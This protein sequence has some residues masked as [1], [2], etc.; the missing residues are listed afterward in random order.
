MRYEL[1][2]WTDALGWHQLDDGSL[3]GTS[4]THRALTAGTTY[5]YAV[6]ALAADGTASDW[7]EHA[8]AIASA[9]QNATA[10]NTPTNTPTS[11]PDAS[12]STPT[13]TSAST[14]TP[15]ATASASA[16]ALSAPTLTAQ[17]GAGQITL[18]WNAISGAVRYE[19]WA[20][21]DA[22]GWHQLDDGGL[23]GTSYTHDD[24][25]P[26][27]TYWYAVRAVAANGAAS[28]WS[29]HAT[30]TATPTAGPTQT[31]TAT[32]QPIPGSGGDPGGPAAP[33]LTTT[34]GTNWIIVDW[35]AVAGAE[36]YDILRRKGENGT[37]ERPSGLPQTTA[38]HGFLGLDF[39]TTYYYIARAITADGKV[40]PWSNLVQDSPTGS[41]NSTPTP[42]S[43]PTATITPTPDGSAA[44]APALRAEAT[45]TNAIELSWPPV[46][47][48]VRYLLWT[49]W[50]AAVG[51]QQ[52]DDGNLTGASYTH[53][54][55]APGT[56]YHYAIR[57]VDANGTSSPW[58]DYPFAT[59]PTAIAVTATATTSTPATATPTATATATTSTLATATPTATTPPPAP[60]AERAALVA[61]YNATGGA[62]W[63]RSANWLSDEPIATWYGVLTDDSGNV[64]GL[65][66]EHNGLSGPL[67]DLSALT[68]LK[69]L[70][71]GYNDLTGPLPD[72]SALA[73]LARL[74]LYINDLSGPLPDLGALTNL[75][76]LYLDGN[77]LTGQIPDLSNL[78][79]LEYLGLSG[80]RLTGQIPDLSNHAS[81][82]SLELNDN[83]LAGQIPD[84]SNLAR[85]EYLGLSGNELTGQIPDLSNLANLTS[86]WL[87][88]NQ[89][90]GQIPDLSN[91]ASLEYLGL[92]GNQLSG[93]IP[94]LSNLVRL[95]NLSLSHNQLTG[96][97]PDLNALANLESVSLNHNRLAGQI[98]ELGA[99]TRLTTLSLNHNLLTG[100]IPDLSTLT[101]LTSLDLSHNQL[102]GSILDLNSL[103][104][105]QTLSL[106]NNQLT[107]PFPDLSALA[108]L[109]FLNLTGNRLC[110]PA[111]SDLSGSN[112]A[113]ANHLNSLNLATCTAA[114]LAAALAAPQ[115]LTATV[116]SG[117]VTLTWDAATRAASYDLRVWDSFDRTWAP[118]GGALRN[119]TYTHT[120]LT[121]GRN[122]YYQVRARD[123]NGVRGA[124]SEQLY[125]AV[126][127]T[128]FPPPPQSFGLDMYYQKYM[129][130][131]GID[132]FA[133]S[134]YTDE[135]MV[136]ARQIITGMLANRSD[137]LATMAANN[138][139]IYVRDDFVGI[140]E[141][142]LAYMP[143]ADPHCAT[144]IHEYAHVIH[145]ALEA[146]A[147]GRAFN[148]RL[149]AAYQAA[150][151][152]GLWRGMYASTNFREYWAEAVKYWLWESLPP[153]LAANYPKPADYDP[154]VVKLIEEE[155]GAAAVP[156][157]CKP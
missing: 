115:N 28:D 86:L 112:T 23:T 90:N 81:L 33:V 22:L 6:R 68:S 2:A 30:A 150:V 66:L 87:N 149:H 105:L 42:T 63:T 72:L 91:L 75:T 143:T 32:G 82:T 3:T 31:P 154:G 78:A 73:N 56:T 21:T 46:P 147:G 55:L 61:L 69:T 109:A 127:P 5:W 79:R 114:E 19:L 136:R 49:W 146:Q 98:P 148:A 67:P 103:T 83:R 14:S 52:L 51:W 122:Y 110:L 4:Y 62:N 120:V 95:T 137:L 44:R 152:G 132:V 41:L 157:S 133:P 65:D 88:D 104:K 48:A 106:N 26:G 135:D 93:Q 54:G 101:N 128:Q 108:N 118:I 70:R 77:E 38:S 107:G 45:Q 151:N 94:N 34:S 57:A 25:V 35:E 10:T 27:R 138:T 84:L 13:P 92:N 43:T 59:V 119:T 99:L 145:F 124:W 1:W 8:S 74:Q 60:G 15:T 85:L 24:P 47:G 9:T 11:A 139:R 97:I 117:Q 58:S 123:A 131:E 130:V 141:P 40:S 142:W 116:G 20:W 16:S 29:E 102:T 140:A 12:T 89:L 96:Q 125:A 111:G 155:I 76:H 36:K 153:L 18:T 71:L 80:N 121:D 17:A 7:S 100:Q 39:G 126:V 64:A 50:N 53:R 113:V 129:A 144:F 37:W 134:V 156:A